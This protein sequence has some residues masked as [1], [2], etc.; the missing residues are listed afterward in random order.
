MIT[1]IVFAR[2]KMGREAV[3]MTDDEIM[4]FVDREIAA[5][6]K[7]KRMRNGVGAEIGF[8]FFWKN[9]MLKAE[10]FLCP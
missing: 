8:T 9:A 4:E 6:R 5:Y 2:L 1:A 10:V 7:E 3:S